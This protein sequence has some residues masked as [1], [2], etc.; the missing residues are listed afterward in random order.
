MDFRRTAIAI[1][2]I[3]AAVGLAASSF[4]GTDAG[5]PSLPRTMQFIQRKLMEEGALNF[6]LYTHDSASG[7]GAGFQFKIETT[8][9]TFDVA[10]C[11]YGR[12]WELLWGP[13]SNKKYSF[14][15]ER[16]GPIK[17][18]STLRVMSGDLWWTQEMAD[19]GAP[20]KSAQVQPALFFVVLSGGNSP[21]DPKSCEKDGAPVACPPLTM[22]DRLTDAWP[23]RDEETAN[24][25]AK[26]MVHAV[27]LCG[28]GNK[29]PF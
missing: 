20:T 7:D 22:M 10:T 6:A 2:G 25:V 17:S 24:R 18:I 12:T 9:F 15:L 16:S 19:E 23:F 13:D 28:G 27:D 8:A 1:A 4:A 26:A 5:S 21:A 3:V 14:H 11:K 29:D